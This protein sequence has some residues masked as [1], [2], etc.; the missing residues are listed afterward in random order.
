M[1][2][3]KFFAAIAM[4]LRGLIWPILLALPLSLAARE[5]SESEISQL[6]PDLVPV[7][8]TLYEEYQSTNLVGTRLELTLKLKHADDRY[9]LF[10]DTQIVVDRETKYYLIKWKFKPEDAKSILGKSN[11]RCK[12]KGRI[13][14]VINGR[15]SPGMPYIVVELLSVQPLGHI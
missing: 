8:E 9:L 1:E 6:N 10:T 5:I 15:T 3:Q 2:N 14:K 7:Y 13:V 11:I 12:V 4:A